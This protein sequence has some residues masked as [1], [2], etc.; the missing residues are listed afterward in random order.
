MI[1][2]TSR[3]LCNGVAQPPSPHPLSEDLY[4]S[5]SELAAHAI[6]PRDV[7]RVCPWAVEYVALD[8]TACWLREELAPLLHGRE[9]SAS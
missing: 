5:T 1:I 7:V 3:S 2:S 4:V 8:G 6:T 9:E